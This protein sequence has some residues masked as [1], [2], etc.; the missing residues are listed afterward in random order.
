VRFDNHLAKRQAQAGTHLAPGLAIL[1]L[2]ELLK[3]ALESFAW[4]PFA[5]VLH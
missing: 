5:R 2:A 3:D 1:D 4:N